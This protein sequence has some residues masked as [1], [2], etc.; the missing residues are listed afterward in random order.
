M[1]QPTP[2]VQYELKKGQQR[3]ASK[4]WLSFGAQKTDDSGQLDTEQ[5]MGRFKGLV[6]IF[7]E[8]GKKDYYETKL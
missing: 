1:P 8:Q 3:G 5:I 2:F 4:G 7:S 6:T